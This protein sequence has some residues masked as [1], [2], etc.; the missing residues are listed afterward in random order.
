MAVVTGVLRASYAYSLMTKTKQPSSEWFREKFPLM[1]PDSSLWRSRGTKEQSRAVS[2]GL[3]TAA[4]R[5]DGPEAA[6]TESPAGEG[7]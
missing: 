3:S 2:G 6:R 7:G 1:A 4:A 5:M